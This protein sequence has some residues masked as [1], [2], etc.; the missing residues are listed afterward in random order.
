MEAQRRLAGLTA[1][2]VEREG[3][4]VMFMTERDYS[5]TLVV[6]TPDDRKVIVKVA[7]NVSDISQENVLDLKLISHYSE[8]SPLAI[9]QFVSDHLLKQGIV[10][11]K[12]GVN[13]VSLSTFRD[14]LKGESPIFKLVKGKYVASVRGEVLRSKREEKG[15]SLGDL[16]SA[17]SVSRNAVY[18]YEHGKMD[19][20]EKVARKLLDLFGDEVLERYNVFSTHIDEEE[21]SERAS[22]GRMMFGDMVEGEDSVLKIERGHIDAIYLQRGRPLFLS[23]RRDEEAKEFAEAVGVQLVEVHG[24]ETGRG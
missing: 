6:R 10:Y 21:L 11:E 13:V 3:G 1:S 23:T 15:M 5:Y 9:S 12:C 7:R 8:A 14:V 24:D 20:G 22:K 19:V 2:I 18:A 4:Q 17:L 16:A